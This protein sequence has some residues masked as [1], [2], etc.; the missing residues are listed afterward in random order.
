MGADCRPGGWRANVLRGV[1][2]VQAQRMLGL[3]RRPRDQAPGA[4]S[5]CPS[6]SKM[7]V[8]CRRPGEVLHA[9]AP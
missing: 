7:Y 1:A 5:R 4:V 6:W 8:A 3:A 2:G 9:G